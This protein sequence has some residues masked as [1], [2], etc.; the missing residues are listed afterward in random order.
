MG[1]IDNLKSLGEAVRKYK[2]PALMEQVIM[3][4]TSVLE[5][6]ERNRKLEEEKTALE[7]QISVKE[8]LFIQDGV[9]YLRTESGN[10]GPYCTRCWDVI[11]KLVIL[12][13]DRQ[14]GYA[15]CPECRNGYDFRSGAQSVGRDFR[16]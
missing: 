7:R 16:A 4:Q 10:S 6:Q 1:L 2:D 5:L 8:S 14:M 3:L 9:Y 12:R 11:N 13:V 15:A